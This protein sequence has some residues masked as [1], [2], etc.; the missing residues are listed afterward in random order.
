MIEF[1]HQIDNDTSS[2]QEAY[3]NIYRSKGILHRD[4][5]YQWLIG[6]L[7]PSSGYS[8]LDISCGEGRLVSIARSMGLKA[9]GMDFAFSGV[10]KGFSNSPDAGWAVADGKSLPVSSTSVDYVT[11][12]GS[13]EHYSHLEP[14]AYEIARIL[15]SDGKACILLPNAFGLTGNIRHVIR[16]GD[17]YDDGQPL[18]RYATYRYW[19]NLLTSAG[20]EIERLIGYEGGSVIKPEKIPDWIWYCKHPGRLARLLIAP[21]IPIYLSNHFIFICRRKRGKS[22]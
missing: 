6:L 15:K 2:F 22:G 10:E 19:E 5:L 7:E 11:H 18:Q 1:K 20:L 8:L 17:V 3:N 9:I 13:L 12:I 16:T 4:A 21:L 14:G